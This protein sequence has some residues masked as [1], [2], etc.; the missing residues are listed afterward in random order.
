M[1]T[2][3]LQGRLGNQFYIISHMIAYAKKHDLEYYIPNVAYHCDGN[4]MYFPNIANGPE[5][6]GLQEYHEQMTHATAKG[7]GTYNYNTPAY[8]DIPKMD[9]VKFIGYWQSFKYFDEYRDL[10]LEKF[11]LPYSAKPTIIGIHVRRGDFLQLQDKHPSIPMSYYQT[12]IDKFLEQGYDNFM[13][14]TDD[15]EWCKTVM[16]DQLS[17]DFSE[18]HVANNPSELSDLIELSSCEHQIL[19]YSTF[20]FIAAWL[21]QNPN[22]QVIIPPSRFNFGGANADMIPNYFTQLKFE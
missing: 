20:G 10:I 16:I 5:L 12:A 13:I 2:T 3:I 22:K 14:Y 9:N 11:Q 18:V 15:H 6:Q 4:N 7:D 19:C 17:F 1:I 21:N 8:H